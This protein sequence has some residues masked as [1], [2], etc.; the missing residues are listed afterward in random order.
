[1]TLLRDLLNYIDARRKVVGG[2]VLSF[3]AVD[4]YND[5]F[6]IYTVSVLSHVGNLIN[7]KTLSYLQYIC[8]LV[9]RITASG[10]GLKM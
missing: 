5:L 6:Y 7:I 8:K 9:V 10:I 3:F 4:I 2:N 1:M